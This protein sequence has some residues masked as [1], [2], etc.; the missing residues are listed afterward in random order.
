MKRNPWRDM[1]EKEARRHDAVWNRAE[2]KARRLD[3]GEISPEPID[4]DRLERNPEIKEPMNDLLKYRF[5]LLLSGESVR[6]YSQ[7][8]HLAE[9]TTRNHME[10]LVR[11]GKATVSP[12]KEP[13]HW[14]SVY[15]PS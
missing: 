2:S 9:R 6:D 14:V 13:G 7:R 12:R 10:R 8:N 3:A 15:T 11:D 4:L 1:A 5:P